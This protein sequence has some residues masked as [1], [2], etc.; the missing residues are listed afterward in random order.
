MPTTFPE[1]EQAYEAKFAHDEEL[2][3]RALARRDK[4]FA[5]WAVGRVVLPEAEKQALVTAALKVPDGHGHD[6]ALLAFFG[7]TLRD[8]G[9]EVSQHELTTALS[10]CFEEAK[11]QIAAS[12]RFPAPGES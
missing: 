8:H 7:Q 6:D 11:A 1:R 4:L 12:P 2:R 9:Q 10:R 3:F 5:A